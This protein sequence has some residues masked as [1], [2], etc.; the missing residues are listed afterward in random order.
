MK[1]FAALAAITTALCALAS[2]PTTAAPAPSGWYGGAAVGTSTVDLTT[3]DWN[4]GTLT[5]QDINNESVAYKLTAGYHFTPYFA[6]ELAY[7]HYGDVKFTGYEP[8]VTP[9]I[10]K[11]GDVFGR[12]EAK[13][14][15]VSG[16]LSWPAGKRYALFARGGIFLFNT[17]MISNPTLSGGTLALSD[18][19]I[20][21]DDGVRFLYGAGME[22]RVYRQWRVRAEWEH[23]TLR[24]AGT[25]DRGVD[26]PSLGVTLDF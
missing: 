15:G 7:T 9:S 26:F 5:K 3:K 25:M 17:T 1:S 8:G 18:R 13:G 21:H 11:S 22:L 14:M 6:G 16:V 20:I 12:A 2:G 23:A 10:W 19:Q 24:F 4:D